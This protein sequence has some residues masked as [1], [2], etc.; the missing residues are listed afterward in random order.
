MNWHI[1]SAALLTAA[2]T[3]AAM[4]AE[5]APVAGVV[6]LSST[7]TAEVTKDLLSI[8]FNTTREGSDAATVQAQLRTALDAALAEAKKGARPGQLDVH[9]GNF[10]LSPRYTNKGVLN[11]WQGSAELVV[12]GRDIAAI[13]QLAGRITTLTIAAAGFDLSRELRASTEGEVASRAIADY[14]AKASDYAKQFGYAGYT[15]REI[16]VSAS[17]PPPVRMLNARMK[18]MAMSSGDEALPVEAGKG[19]VSISVNGTVQLTR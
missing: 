16:D 19:T 1:A 2:L 11:G 12:S 3:P 15:L 5:A 7:A 10:S 6:R 14:R 17:E 8:T 13:G 9:T 4:A 18:T